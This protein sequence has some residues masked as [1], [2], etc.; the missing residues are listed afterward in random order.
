MNHIA[1][2]VSQVKDYF[3]FAMISKVENSEQFSVLD[4]LF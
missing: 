2:K 3:S 1:Y 4:F